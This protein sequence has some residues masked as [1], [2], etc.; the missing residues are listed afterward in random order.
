MTNS[1]LYLLKLVH[2]LSKKF[3]VQVCEKSKS[4]PRKIFDAINKI[5][6]NESDLE[7]EA[8]RTNNAKMSVKKKKPVRYC[9]PVPIVLN[10][11]L[12]QS[13]RKLQDF[14]TSRYRQIDLKPHLIGT[15]R[16]NRWYL[17]GKTTRY[18]VVLGRK[19]SKTAD[20]RG[21]D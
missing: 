9:S 14:Y 1:F 11:F 6:K 20:S 7:K 3:C 13:G 8:N 4:K 18:R 17:R 15:P 16:G 5:W 21:R 2:Q 12:K 19:S 10:I